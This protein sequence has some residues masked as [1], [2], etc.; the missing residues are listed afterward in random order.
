MILLSAFLALSPQ[1]PVSP[2]VLYRPSAMPSR[3]RLT[4]SGDPA[5]TQSVTWRTDDSVTAPV[6]QI[7]LAG[8][9]P[10]IETKGETHKGR[11]ETV[12]SDLGWKVGYHTVTFTNLQPKTQYVYR[13]GDGTNWSEWFHFTTAAAKFEP[14]SF[15]Y[16]GDA[17]NGIR[18]LW[19]R[20]F[21]RAYAEDTQARFFLYAGD[22]INRANSDAEWAELYDGPGWVNASTPTIPVSGNHEHFKNAAGEPQISDHW[23]PQFELPQN[24]IPGL[25][26][27]NYVLDYQ[28]VRIIALNSTQRQKE[29]TPW[30]EAQLK[31]NPNRWTVVCF[32]HPIYSAAV[33]R[34]NPE[35]RAMW[36]PLFD[37]YRVDLVLQGHDHTYA[38]NDFRSVRSSIASKESEGGT[39][40]VVSVSGSKMY[41]LNKQPWMVRA[42]EDTQL[43]QNL[44]V[45]WN[46]VVYEARTASGELYD[47]FTIQKRA[48]KPNRLV[49]Q[50]PKTPEKIRPME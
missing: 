8:P 48:G 14:F 12:A 23:R 16:L 34:D 6:A 37:R 35:L 3:V 44:K 28:G 4:W 5:T 11:S 27:S 38:R 25:E 42:A 41:D 18:T 21:R 24:G 45:T 47:K 46:E 17:Q 19:A 50:K 33:R 22:L 29:Q 9:G 20:V 36:K 43:Y 13:V 10:E 30:L 26:E 1:T 2:Q 39:M 32:H 49:D 31:H 7:A 15:I 40:Y